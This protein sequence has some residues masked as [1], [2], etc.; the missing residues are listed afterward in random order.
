MKHLFFLTTCLFLVGITNEMKAAELSNNAD[1]KATFE[2]EP[3]QKGSVILT[4]D[5]LYFGI[6]QQSH[7]DIDAKA[8]NA[9]A[10]KVTE[11]SGGKPG[12]VLKV[13]LDKFTSDSDTAE[14]LQLFYPNVVPKTSVVS[15]K[16]Y[17]P[18][19]KGTDD[20]FFSDVT[21]K[22]TIVNDDKAPIILAEAAEGHGYGDWEFLYSGD[23]V[24]QLKIPTGQKVG[25]YK[26]VLTY[27]VEDVPTSF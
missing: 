14:G 23:N 20:S 2:L 13:T 7:L 5:D 6:H 1:T 27:T 15:G 12:W 16:P 24:V 19:S 18:V 4:A 11:F 17:A 3:N 21:N 22:G 10:I 25:D 9:V 8:K 26:A